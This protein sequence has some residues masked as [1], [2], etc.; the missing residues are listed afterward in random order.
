MLFNI[1]EVDPSLPSPE[2]ETAIKKAIEDANKSL[3]KI[4]DLK[5]APLVQKELRQALASLAEAEQ[6]LKELQKT[7]DYAAKSAKLEKTEKSRQ[8]SALDEAHRETIK[9]ITG[10]TTTTETSSD[11]PAGHIIDP[12]IVKDLA[13]TEKE[14][15]NLE[16]EL[17]SQEP[18]P[19]ELLDARGFLDNATISMKRAQSTVD[20]AGIN[21]SRRIE[22]Y[23]AMNAMRSAT[24][25]LGMARNKI[26]SFKKNNPEIVAA[27]KS[28]TEPDT[29]QKVKEES[30]VTLKAL[31]AMFFP[32]V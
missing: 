2:T 24:N 30:P 28:R 20:L 25:F 19:K 5:D 10:Q 32:K 26:D 7:G 27:A 6:V 22:A 12:E 4:K 21:G 9:I 14:L 18:K 17:S 23:D 31:V 16:K 15:L 11:I 29:V 13:S 8:S 3:K 1:K